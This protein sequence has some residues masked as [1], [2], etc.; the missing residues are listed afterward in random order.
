MIPSPP[1]PLATPDGEMGDRDQF[2]LALAQD[3]VD[4]EARATAAA[5]ITIFS[6]LLSLARNETTISYPSASAGA[7][8]A[9]RVVG[10]GPAT[11]PPGGI[12]NLGITDADGVTTLLLYYQPES[13]AATYSFASIIAGASGGVGLI[14]GATSTSIDWPGIP[15]PDGV[16]FGG[17]LRLEKVGG[18]WRLR[19]GG[20]NPI[21]PVT[22][23]TGPYTGAPLWCII[24][25]SGAYAIN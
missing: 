21:A 12:I 4:A 5:C 22:P 23:T 9:P 19:N 25:P 3:A 24:Y 17:G 7:N 14:L 13:V 11:L 16:A 2:E 8:V 15:G 18:V 6:V 1:S 20:M 10:P